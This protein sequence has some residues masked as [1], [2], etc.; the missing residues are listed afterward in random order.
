MMRRSGERKIW[1]VNTVLAITIIT[2]LVFASG[3][4]DVFFGSQNIDFG[5]SPVTT[6]QT[7]VKAC[8]TQPN[9]LVGSTGTQLPEA[10]KILHLLYDDET[11]MSGDVIVWKDGRTFDDTLDDIYMYNIATKQESP[12]I[13]VDDRQQR[14][15]ISGN[16]IAYSNWTDS[17]KIHVYDLNTR[18]DIAIPTDHRA[19]TVDIDGKRV[20]F[21]DLDKR[22]VVLY[23][24][25]TGKDTLVMAGGRWPR[26]SGDH[27]IYR[28]WVNNRDDI[29]L[30]N[31]PNKKETCI[32][33]GLTE[34]P[35]SDYRIDG[36]YVV[37]DM[38]ST[39]EPLRLYN[40]GTRATSEIV[41]CSGKCEYP[42]ANMCGAW[43]DI[44]GNN[45][46]YASGVDC[47]ECD[48]DEGV[49]IYNIP[50]LTTKALHLHSSQDTDNDGGLDCRNGGYPRISGN[51]VIF[52]QG[53]EDIYLIKL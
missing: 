2:G 27:V 39:G 22:S 30:Y 10:K 3:C 28:K 32:S 18:K 8:W 15:A 52:W 46:V 26:I 48:I 42:T 6:I 4:L 40:I 31:I 50:D 36:N 49:F 24:I 13:V 19:Q 43:Y 5:S 21:E 47:T 41:P 14:P 34:E 23:D 35:T 53:F 16:L 17:K 25:S 9:V 7:P 1:I 11:E 44:S 37:F 29:Y 12:L 38:S 20:V 33:C 51:N 45:V